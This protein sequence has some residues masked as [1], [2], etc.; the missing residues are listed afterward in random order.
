MLLIPPFVWL[1]TTVLNDV[2][3]IWLR[4]V[5]RMGLNNSLGRV[6]CRQF[7]SSEMKEAWIF[8][9]ALR[10]WDERGDVLL[11]HKNVFCDIKNTGIPRISN[12]ISSV[13]LK[14][15]HIII[16]FFIKCQDSTEQRGIKYIML[17]NI[18]KGLFFS[19]CGIHL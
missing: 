1:G 13:I 12:Y 18:G 2:D 10:E 17:L 5:W 3:E 14:I 15:Q 11:W 16:H 6:E 9:R 8:E 19:R 7:F 4:V